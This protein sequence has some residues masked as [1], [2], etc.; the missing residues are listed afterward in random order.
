MLQNATGLEKTI[1]SLAL[2]DVD[3]TE[4][5]LL[6]NFPNVFTLQDTFDLLGKF[7]PRERFA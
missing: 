1:E 4:Y 7:I 2:D 3:P 6:A 5:S